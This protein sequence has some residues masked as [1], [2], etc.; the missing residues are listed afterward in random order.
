MTDPCYSPDHP[1]YIADNDLTPDRKLM[2]RKLIIEKESRSKATKWAF[3]G[4]ILTIC[5]GFL[6]R[7]YELHRISEREDVMCL[8]K[9]DVANEFGH[10]EHL[11]AKDYMSLN[12]RC[13][14]TE[15]YCRKIWAQS[16]VSKNQESVVK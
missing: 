1:L 11:I 7:E 9:E 2:L 10:M 14:R 5:A 4:V 6:Y 8:R 16:E 3:I 15:Q 13:A 12:Q